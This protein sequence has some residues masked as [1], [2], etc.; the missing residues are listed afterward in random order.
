MIKRREFIAGLGG[1]AVWPL[2]ARAQQPAL[3]EIGYLGNFGAFT[4][5]PTAF[6]KGLSETGYVEGQNVAIEYRWTEG[7]NDPL[8]ALPFAKDLVERRVSVIV[9]AT[10]PLAIAVKSVTRTIPIVVRAGTDPVAAG[11]VASLSRPGANVTG[12]S[13]FSPGLGAEAT[14]VA[15]RILPKGSSVAVLVSRTVPLM[16]QPSMR[17]P[18]R[19]AGGR[20]LHGPRLCRDGDRRNLPPALD[21]T[22]ACRASRLGNSAP[23]ILGRAH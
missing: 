8:T 12:I 1:A 17:S 20:R 13:T 22:F 7:P 18:R 16:G 23:T 6:R 15:A 3:P 14:G 2:A 11:L 21:R 10:V 19:G 9:A 5:S 4:S